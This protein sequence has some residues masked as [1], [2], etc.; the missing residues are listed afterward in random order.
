MLAGSVAGPYIEN[1]IGRNTVEAHGRIV[2]L[3]SET[4]GLIYKSA[5]NPALANEED[6]RF[7]KCESEYLNCY[8]LPVHNSVELQDVISDG[9]GVMPSEI[10]FT[11]IKATRLMLWM[12]FLSNDLQKANCQESFSTCFQKVR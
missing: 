2:P 8:S 1:T 5:S 6:Q 12:A 7:G 4:R 11:C 3:L 9:C 10:E